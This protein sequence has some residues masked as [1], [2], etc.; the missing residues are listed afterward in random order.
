VELRLQRLLAV[1]WGQEHESTKEKTCR[2]QTLT[3][4]SQFAVLEPCADWNKTWVLPRHLELPI[5]HNTKTPSFFN[6]LHSKNPRTT[7]L[8]TTHSTTFS[9]S[10]ALLQPPA[11]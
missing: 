7:H 3:G 1:R 5:T 10:E 9:E 11:F 4:C 2:R 8:A 6:I